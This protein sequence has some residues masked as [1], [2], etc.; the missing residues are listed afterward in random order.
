MNDFVAV[1]FGQ[2]ITISMVSSIVTQV[3]KVADGVHPYVREIPVIGP[4]LSWLID[5]VTPED[6]GA[7]RI[8]VALLC[9]VMN[10]IGNYWTEGFAE[11]NLQLGVQTLVSF[12]MATGAYDVLLRYFN[13]PSDELKPNIQ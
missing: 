2:T 11:F 5:T 6:P 7:I 10:I 4:S 1:F 8:F 9:F 12:L 13:R 3:F